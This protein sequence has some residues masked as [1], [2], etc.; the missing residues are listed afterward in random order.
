MS[1][2]NRYLR[3]EQRPTALAL[4]AALAAGVRAAGDGRDAVLAA[5][6]GVLESHPEL[7]IDR[8]DLVDPTTLEDATS[9]PAR[10]L[11]AGILAGQ[12]GPVR[13]I[14]NTALKLGVV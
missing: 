9:G 13:L 8:L 3:P 5:A 4:S 12:S 1:S 11:V 7:T 2:R 14:D 6:R 10:L